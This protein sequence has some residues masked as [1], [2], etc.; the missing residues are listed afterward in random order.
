MQKERWR[1]FILTPLWYGGKYTW[2]HRPIV[3]R[4]LIN[5]FDF[6]LVL[7]AFFSYVNLYPLISYYN[8]ACLP[9]I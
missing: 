2:F 8:S 5:Y 6:V 9:L 1:R 3:K 7:I 4:I